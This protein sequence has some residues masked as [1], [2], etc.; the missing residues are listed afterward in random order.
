MMRYSHYKNTGSS[1]LEVLVATT[2]VSTTLV[3]IVG[4]IM[5]SVS[6]TEQIRYQEQAAGLSQ[7]MMEVFFKERATLGWNMFLSKMASAQ[8]F[9]LNNPTNPVEA[10]LGGCPD[11][12]DSINLEGVLFQRHAEVDYV[13]D[14]S[15]KHVTVK[16]VTTWDGGKVGMRSNVLTHQF[17]RIN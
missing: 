14:N 3:A 9:C 15:D 8:R 17:R 10:Q 2:V 13:N 12:N 6:R 5:Y 7:D 1:L 4:V 11:G 16:V